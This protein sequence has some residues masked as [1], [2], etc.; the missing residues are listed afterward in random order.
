MGTV[1]SV[2]PWNEESL[3][4]AL[5]SLA[6][7]Q[8]IKAGDLFMLI[9]VAITGSSVAPPLFQSMTILGRERCLA[10]LGRAIDRLGAPAR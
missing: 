10:R 9:R 5:R 7:D 8:S 2:D 6:E 1:E 4:R 3:E